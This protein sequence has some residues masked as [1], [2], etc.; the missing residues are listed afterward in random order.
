MLNQTCTK[1]LNT[2]S[3]I[4]QEKVRCGQSSTLRKRRLD[5]FNNLKDTHQDDPDDNMKECMRLLPRSTCISRCSDKVQNSTTNSSHTSHNIETL[6]S[7]FDL[8]GK[9]LLVEGL[10]IGPNSSS[11]SSSPSAIASPPPHGIENLGVAAA[12]GLLLKA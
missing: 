4:K 7:Y 11:P 8:T 1:L 12:P 2:T 9:F 6:A 10:S 5:S 3:V